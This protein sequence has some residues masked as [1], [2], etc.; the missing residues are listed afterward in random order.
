[1]ATGI[2]PCST[3]AQELNEYTEQLGQLHYRVELDEQ[4]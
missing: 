2:F 3:T 4:Q 1:M